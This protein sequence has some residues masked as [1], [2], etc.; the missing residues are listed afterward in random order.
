MDRRA[1]PVVLV[2]WLRVAVEGASE[3]A[4][5]VPPESHLSHT[6]TMIINPG[7]TSG[8][9]EEAPHGIQ[10]TGDPAH[11]VPVVGGCPVFVAGVGLRRCAARAAR[12]PLARAALIPP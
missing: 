8:R 2:R 11:R 7:E 5:D 3:M 4:H 1:V 6:E 9:P 12:R 10:C